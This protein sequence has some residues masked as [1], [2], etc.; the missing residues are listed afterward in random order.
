MRPH[1]LRPWWWLLAAVVLVAPLC[2]VV[3]APAAGAAATCVMNASATA[4]TTCSLTSWIGAT[5]DAGSSTP[6]GSTPTFTAAAART[7]I[8]ADA[9]SHVAVSAT[10]DSSD[11]SYGEPPACTT[12]LP[13]AA[14]R[15]RGAANVVYC[16]YWVLGQTGTASG[17]TG[18]VVV[19]DEVDWWEG[20]A[21]KGWDAW[22]MPYAST[23]VVYTCVEHGSGC[24]TGSDVP[25]LSLTDG[26]LCEHV[27]LGGSTTPTTAWCSIT[28][29]LTTS[30]THVANTTFS[31]WPSFDNTSWNQPQ[32]TG[33]SGSSQLYLQ[34]TGN[35]VV[36]TTASTTV[37]W[38]S[39]STPLCMP[40]TQTPSTGGCTLAESSDTSVQTPGS[41][42]SLVL[43]HQTS[44]TKSTGNSTHSCETSAVNYEGF[45]NPNT[46]ESPPA[47]C[48][49]Y[50]CPVDSTSVHCEV[51]ISV[52]SAGGDIYLQWMILEWNA[53]GGYGGGASYAFPLAWSSPLYDSVTPAPSG[54]VP[55]DSL[56]CW[57]GSA[58]STSCTA[59]TGTDITVSMQLSPE[60]IYDPTDHSGGSA[61]TDAPYADCNNVCTLTVSVTSALVGG[62][63]VAVTVSSTGTV[64]GGTYGT[65][66]LG[67][68]ENGSV[69]GAYPTT[70]SHTWH[71]SN[72]DGTWTPDTATFTA[73]YIPICT[74][75]YPTTLPDRVVTGGETAGPE[76]SAS[77]SWYDYTVAIALEGMTASSSYWLATGTHNPTESDGGSPA[78]VT[79]PIN[80][81][82]R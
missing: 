18:T 33:T 9:G 20:N 55:T 7:T 71:I 24:N 68:E 28:G 79:P 13:V 80:T 38:S 72:P 67:L 17:Y 14:T 78:V 53:A 64:N 37:R 6:N 39:M 12:A 31:N 65:C 23:S 41:R 49:V 16:G 19:T 82:Q 11:T 35:L 26:N 29:A 54:P 2:S 66:G 10:W 70:S 1:R 3:A 5:Y 45:K 46:R 30:G 59:Q 40:V 74:D 51:T 34:W 69:V 47:D 57:D 15:I 25:Y 48:Q 77:G 22:R 52:P 44:P 8:T 21:A 32:T 36:K 56:R 42:E 27:Y 60:R 50:Q 43:Y 75:N 81:E 58:W 62:T 73:F 4:Q 61:S 63:E 76:P